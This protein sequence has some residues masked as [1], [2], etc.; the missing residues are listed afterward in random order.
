VNRREEHYL[1]GSQNLPNRVDPNGKQGINAACCAAVQPEIDDM[2]NT[3]S[4]LGNQ[5]Q[6]R[7][8]IG[9][10]I[11]PL[12]GTQGAQA[13]SG[14]TNPA[15]RPPCINDAINA[16][17]KNIGISAYRILWV[18]GVFGITSSL[19]DLITGRPGAAS[20][21]FA[22]Y[23]MTQELQAHELML[24][25]L[26]KVQADCHKHLLPTCPPSAADK[27]LPKEK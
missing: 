15:L 8:T 14:V 16:V 4:W 3:I 27:W 20:A 18:M 26:L 19:V 21:D 9:Q 17:E 25:N 7:A 22:G 1:Y 10:L 11:G 23:W 13:L 12:T 5:I 24:S 2:K 6:N